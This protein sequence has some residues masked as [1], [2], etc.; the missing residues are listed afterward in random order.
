MNQQRQ[1]GNDSIWTEVSTPGYL[2]RVR[3]RTSKRTSPWNLLLIP[4]SFCGFF[5]IPYLLFR[6]MWAVHILLYPAHGGHLSEFWGR[7]I[8]FS[9]FVSS[10][11]LLLP[12]VFAGIPIS[13]L[14]ANCVTWCIPAARRAFQREGEVEIAYSFPVAMR[15]LWRVS[16]A[17]IPI[18]LLL[19]L[20]GAATLT[21]LK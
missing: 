18:C 17:M 2:D 13:M 16:R 1:R 8:G 4:L 3:G 19:S 14:M 15:Q 10:F 12:L 5:M 9:A 6:C 20:L 7:G 21:N 11:L